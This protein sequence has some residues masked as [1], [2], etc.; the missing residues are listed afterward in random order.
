MF[1]ALDCIQP[2]SALS[3]VQWLGVAALVSAAALA[4][5]W[6]RMTVLKGAVR[7]A[8]RLFDA[9]AREE[10][11]SLLLDTTIEQLPRLPRGS[12]LNAAGERFRAALKRQ[13]GWLQ[14]QQH[15][16]TAMEIRLAKAGQ[17]LKRLREIVNR[18]PAPIIAVDE[19]RDVVVANRSAAELLGFDGALPEKRAAEQL[20]HCEK[21][22]ELLTGAGRSASGNGRS[23]EIELADA[24]GESRAYRVTAARL[25]GREGAA[26]GDGE[27]GAVALLEDIGEQRLLQKRNAEFVASVSHE[28]KTP[29]AG[30]KA[31]VELLADGDADDEATRDEFLGVI[32]SQAERLQRLVENMLN[33]ARIEAGVVKVSKEEQSLNT[34]LEEALRV[35]QPAAEAK[36]ITLSGELSPMHLQVRVD[37]DMLLQAAINLLSNAV[38]YTPAGG[39][40]ALRSKMD[41]DLAR[42]EVADTG[43]G[44]SP[45]DCV[46]VFERF[47]RVN[48]DKSMAAGTGLG[49]PLAKHILE[50]V[51]G[52][53]LYVESKL[54]EG[55]TFIAELPLATKRD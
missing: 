2:F 19:Y 12:P 13:A 43:V 53:R 18:L 38:K 14:D 34:I 33:L 6:L 42:F 29:L 52:G 1:A 28:M 54:G 5:T 32:A 41:S 47:Y 36:S 35:V 46:K 31:Y 45:D 11:E 26:H 9:I 7:D 23:G 24:Q 30:I 10:A 37:R 50:D 20:L 27:R 39:K 44:L 25:A 8:V 21:L 4:W 17:E 3:H 40:V 16:R 15:C 48:K 51:H 49:L 55:S 22:V